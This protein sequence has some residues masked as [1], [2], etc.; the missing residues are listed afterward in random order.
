MKSSRLYAVAVGALVLSTGQ[1]AQAQ[2]TGF[3]LNRFDPAERGSDW[4]VLESLDF[5]GHLRPAAGLVGDWA[6]KP[7]VTY[8][9]SGSE[10]S[11]LVKNQLFV[12]LGGALIMWDRVRFAINVPVALYQSGVT[13]T[14]GGI[15]YPAPDS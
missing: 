12:H 4:F 5:R 14:V 3:A 13:S 10:Q 7:L 2:S 15:Q 11:A 8:T 1:L 9:Q 6:Y